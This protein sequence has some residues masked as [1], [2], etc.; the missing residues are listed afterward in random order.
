[1]IKL[2]PG[3]M[4]DTR[5]PQALGRAINALQTFT[6]RDGKAVFSHSGIIQ[7]RKGKT[8]EALWTLKEQNLFD[9]Y[10]GIR[11]Q[12]V[13]WEG[14]DEPSVLPGMNPLYAHNALKKLKA[15]HEGQWYPWWR[16]PFHIF[17]PVAK[18][19]S[20]KGKWV[21]CSELTAKFL[22]YCHLEMGEPIDEQG[23]KWPR[24]DQFCGTCP[25]ILSD[26]AHRWRGYRTIYD[27]PLNRN[28][29]DLGELK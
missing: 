2:Q 21:V 8:F 26:E 20:Y 25:D 11:V 4:F 9:A 18:Y 19:V 12:I 1:M 27:K 24:H 29:F 16:L 6:S 5:N 10:E 28:D 23:V 22:W 14:V 3:D 7:N 13:R 15:E 17:P